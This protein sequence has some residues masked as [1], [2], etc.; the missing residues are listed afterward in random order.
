M[1]DLKASVLTDQ[2]G[3]L[4]GVVR[5]NVN[6]DSRVFEDVFDGRCRKRAEESDLKKVDS[7]AFGFKGFHT[8]NHGAFGGAP[9]DHGDLSVFGAKETPLGFLR[10]FTGRGLDFAHPLGV[11]LEPGLRLLGDVANLIVLV[12]GEPVDPPLL[13]QE[14]PW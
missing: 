14:N 7:D 3:K 5:F 9:T 1:L 11:H 2:R 10:N 13:T 8:V 4:T 12:P 6:D